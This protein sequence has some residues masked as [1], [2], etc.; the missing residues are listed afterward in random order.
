M[1]LGLKSDNITQDILNELNEI[2]GV[3]KPETHVKRL[4]FFELNDHLECEALQ[5]S[6]KSSHMHSDDYISF[7]QTQIEQKEENPL[8][9]S[10]NRSLISAKEDEFLQETKRFNELLGKNPNNVEIWLDFINFQKKMFF[11]LPNSNKNNQNITEKQLSI[12]EKALENQFLK[13]NPLLNLMKIKLLKNANKGEDFFKVC[14]GAW[15][16]NLEREPE[17][18]LFWTLFFDF[19]FSNF[20]KFNV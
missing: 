4:R 10:L 18:S 7:Q 9:F 15:K 13:D 12:V 11:Y 2:Q 20:I 14:E 6:F 17:N 8:I 16:E 5:K 3:L 1:I 19:K